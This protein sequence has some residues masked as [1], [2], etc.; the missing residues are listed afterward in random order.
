MA[1]AYPKHRVAITSFDRTVNCRCYDDW[2]YPLL[3]IS[4]EVPLFI[5]LAINILESCDYARLMFRAARLA[6]KQDA[7]RAGRRR[8]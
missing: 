1:P 2:K 8:W 3:A 4:R 7:V 6:G 5:V